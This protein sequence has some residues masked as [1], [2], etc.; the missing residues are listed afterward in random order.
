MPTTV[1]AMT[2]NAFKSGVRLIFGGVCS[3]STTIAAAGSVRADARRAGPD[4]IPRGGWHGAGASSHDECSGRL[5]S[6]WSRSSRLPGLK[7]AFTPAGTSREA[8]AVTRLRCRN[9]HDAETPISY[10]PSPA[11]LRPLEDPAAFRRAWPIAE[12]GHAARPV[13]TPLDVTS[14]CL[15]FPRAIPSGRRRRVIADPVNWPPSEGFAWHRPC[16]QRSWK[17]N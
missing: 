17:V 8:V 5:G 9:D 2:S 4:R 16:T 6:A 14:L 1:S 3:Y 11:K 10:A 7:T 15:G 12:T 13:Y